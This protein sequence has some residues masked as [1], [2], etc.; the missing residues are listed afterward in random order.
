MKISMGTVTLFRTT[1]GNPI[2]DTEK[3]RTKWKF[4]ICADTK[5]HIIGTAICSPIHPRGDKGLCEANTGNSI[6]TT[7]FFLKMPLKVK[8]HSQYI[9]PIRKIVSRGEGGKFR[10]LDSGK[11]YLLWMLCYSSMEAKVIT[12]WVCITSNKI[13]ASE[14][15]LSP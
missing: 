4:P 11:V 14:L 13:N 1:E 12:A 7:V 8:M 3:H 6:Y 9:F 2:N 15:T 5:G 10:I